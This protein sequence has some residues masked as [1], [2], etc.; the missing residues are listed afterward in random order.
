MNKH[1]FLSL[2]FVVM[3]SCGFSQT[4]INSTNSEADNN[5]ILDVSSTNKGFLLPRL[6]T[7]Q[8]EAIASPPGGLIVF[9][10]TDKKIYCFH[11]GDNEWKELDIGT[12][13]LDP[14]AEYT[15]GTGSSCANSV[16]GGVYQE[17]VN[18]TVANTVVLEATFTTTGPWSIYTDT[19]NGYYFTGSG[20]ISST[21]V[22]NIVL[23]A[24]GTPA[25]SQT[26]N[27]A[28][29]ANNNG[30]T[31]TFDIVV[32]NSPEYPQGATNCITG[33]T[34][35]S[36]V[37]NPTTGEV[38][39]DRNLGAS[40]VATSASDPDAIG[41]LYQWG[42]LSDGHQCRT[43]STTSTL[44]ATSTPG[45]SNFIMPSTSPY[46][47]LSPQDNQLWQGEN[48]TNNPCPSGY[49]IPTANEWNEERLSW[50][51]P[52]SWGANDS[53][54]KLPNVGIRLYED[55]SISGTGSY[56]YYWCSDT[57]GIL[58]RGLFFRPGAAYISTG[59]ARG[60]GMAV[61]CIKVNPA[62]YSIGTGGSC[63]NTTVDG[64][65]KAGILLYFENT[66]Q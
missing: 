63:N 39:M 15:I 33:G 21:G 61:R 56:G 20:I 27:F 54:L 12:S 9:C 44:S 35:V 23:I 66:V 14:Y 34:T 29:T 65:Y 8:I 28:A 1:I 31:C 16:I 43:S 26:D 32:Y 11:D 42:R 40:Q 19:I 4:A 30:G 59:L 53:Y 62:N 50:T 36:D 5:A 6:T 48:G 3:F 22:N 46:D 7:V 25:T 49:R 2:L 18:L 64:S 51:S 55:G 17:S 57:E 24:S 10:T 13:T 41:D 45:H 58:S 52:T 38:W 60:Y 47:W 37:F